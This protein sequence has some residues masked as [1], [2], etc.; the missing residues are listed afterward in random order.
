[1]TFYGPSRG[2]DL[3]VGFCGFEKQP[4]FGSGFRIWMKTDAMVLALGD[5]Y[6]ERPIL[7][8]SS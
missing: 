5:C 8:S 1:M 6:S 2:T 4:L 3:E 7:F